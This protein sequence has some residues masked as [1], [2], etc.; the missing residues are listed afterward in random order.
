MKAVGEKA[1]LIRDLC[2]PRPRNARFLRLAIAAAILA[3]PTAAYMTLMV[4]PLICSRATAVLLSPGSVLTAYA[5]LSP[6]AIEGLLKPSPISSAVLAVDSL[7][8]FLV[9]WG[10][11]C[12][13]SGLLKPADRGRR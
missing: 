8:W 2:A 5:A 4:N 3:F 11:F 6:K 7:Y 13:V 1:S 10:L 12:C 9:F